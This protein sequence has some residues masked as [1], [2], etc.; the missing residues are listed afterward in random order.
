MGIPLVLEA[1]ITPTL[2]G[3][4]I[5]KVILEFQGG[6]ACWDDVTCSVADAVFSADIEDTRSAV[7]LYRQGIYD[8]DNPDNPFK[9]WTHVMVPYCPVVLLSVRIPTT[10]RVRISSPS[11]TAATPMH[12]RPFRGFK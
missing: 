12:C 11:A 7:G 3:P 2:C 8:H 10:V 4:E 5:Q 1:P 6:G 9:G